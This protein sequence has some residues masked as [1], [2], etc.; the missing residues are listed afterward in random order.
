MD[1]SGAKR[2]AQWLPARGKRPQR[3]VEVIEEVQ[4]RCRVRLRGG[5]EGDYL[6]RLL[7]VAHPSW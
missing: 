4:G 7:Q 1:W 2:R 3:L 6:K 5:G